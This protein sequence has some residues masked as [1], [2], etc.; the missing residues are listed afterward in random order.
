MNDTRGSAIRIAGVGHALFAVTMIALG[1]AGLVRG[2]FV[3]IWTGVPKTFPARTAL[4]YLCALVSLGCGIGVLFRRSSAV[5]SR[6]LLV[7]FL[8]WILLFRV[9]LVVHDPTSSGM[10]WAVAET[11]AMA[12]AAWVLYVWFAGEKNGRPAAFAAGAGG[13]RIA[14]ALYGFALIPFGI[15]HFTF[16]ERTIGMVPDWLPWHVFWADFFGVAFI[17]AGVGIVVDIFGRLAAVLS[18]FEMALFTVLVW[19]P[20][21]AAGH[22]SESDKT[23]FIGSCILTGAAWLV[24]DSYRGF[25]WASRGKRSRGN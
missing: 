12:G 1:V 15:A 22:P 10:W 25:S 21:M 23:E 19:I 4:A 13:L 2:G 5:A 9:P 18:T 24:A 16:H 7:W 3:P 14:R 11:A 17:A 6:V 8:F 20:V